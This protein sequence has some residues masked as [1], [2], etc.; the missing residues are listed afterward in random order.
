LLGPIFADPR[1]LVLM[2]DEAPELDEPDDPAAESVAITESHPD[3]IHLDVSVSATGMVV[4]S[5]IWDPGW[6]A[7]V[8][9]EGVEVYRVNHTLRGI[10]VEP[11][12]QEIVLRY[13]ATVVK[14]SLLFYIVP[15]AALLALPLLDRRR[16]PATV[17]A[18]PPGPRGGE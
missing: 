12:Q 2:E 5:E 18:E 11:G 9:G 14:T 8:D 6:S 10:V 15:V 7:T 4:L 3:E 13:K 16:R 1:E 17:A